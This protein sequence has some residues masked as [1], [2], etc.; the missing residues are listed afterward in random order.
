MASLSTNH[1]LIWFPA[2]APVLDEEG[3]TIQSPKLM[4]TVV[5]NPHGFYLV[6]TLPERM[7]FN[8]NYYVT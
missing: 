2:G 6:D 1:E 4:L 5:W 3:H 7:K 8:G